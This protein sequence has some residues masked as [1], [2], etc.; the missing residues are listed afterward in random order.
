MADLALGAI[1]NL[2]FSQWQLYGEPLVQSRLTQCM[3]RTVQVP[4][5]HTNLKTHTGIMAA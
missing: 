1:N 2:G 4:V 5:L 3:F